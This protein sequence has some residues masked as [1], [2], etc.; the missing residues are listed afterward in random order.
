MVPK[1]RRDAAQI[2]PIKSAPG[3]RQDHPESLLET[4]S[5]PPWSFLIILTAACVCYSHTLFYEFTRFDDDLII[6]NNVELYK[7]F[8]RIG[9][10]FTKDAF[11]DAIGD[12]FYRPM[13]NLSF[14]V[15]A[16]MSG[17]KPI[18]FK[19]TNLMLHILTC[20]SIYYLFRLLILDFRLSF[21]S[22]LIYSAHPLFTSAVIWIPSRGDL[23]IALFG[24]LSYITFIKYFETSRIYF[25]VLH[26]LMLFIAVFSKETAVIFPVI[27][28]VHLI[29]S[30]KR[31]ERIRRH[32]PAACTWVFVLSIY[33][34]CRHMVILAPLRSAEFGI[35][36]FIYNLRTIP[37]FL[38]KFILPFDLSVM[39]VFTAFATA[40]GTV[41]LGLL[42]CVIWR[43]WRSGEKH[44]VLGSAWFLLFTAITMTY[45][46][47]LGKGA[48]DYLEHRAYLPT[49][50]VLLIMALFVQNFI[51]R[52]HLKAAY[53]TGFMVCLC[54][55]SLT[56]YYGRRYQNPMTFY[57][58][59]IRSNPN[60]AMA[61]YNRAK[62]KYTLGDF[63]GAMNDYDLAIR[64]MPD[65]AEAYNN[66][67]NIKRTFGDAR[68][69]LVDYDEAIKR[70]GNYVQAYFN[71]G[72]V[73]AGLG[74]NQGA[75]EDYTS[76]VNLDP[77]LVQAWNNR[78][79]IYFGLGQ[80]GPALADFDRAIHLEPRFADA[81]RN[82]GW[83]R[84]KEGDVNGACADWKNGGKMGDRGAAKLVQQYCR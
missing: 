84:F 22:A 12:T 77:A 70:N 79:A 32:L 45:R 35:R 20:I 47:K 14:Y 51:K 50:G 72:I 63:K 55:C 31:S 16:Q 33:F 18:G 56:L 82:R 40:A 73:R 78:G 67:G 19:T 41:L 71:R 48:Y 42:G 39:P 53:Y 54:F 28:A 25:L 69:A 21:L 10:S 4:L 57:E 34:Y 24:T 1:R 38:S 65:F 62:Y 9:E 6:I 37:E 13:Q 29:T 59:A 49:I 43:G 66:R 15:D 27:F 80:M 83:V 61:F 30:G 76:A 52:H 75:A 11:N 46:N 2:R 26:T 74:D 36:P 81:W 68:G 58:S 17:A 23:L 8:S 3:Y 64:A 60:C 5:L 44:F 7:D